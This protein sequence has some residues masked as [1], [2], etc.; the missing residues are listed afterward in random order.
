MISPEMLSHVLIPHNWKEFG[1]H[2]GCSFNLTS[3][4]NAG[5]IAGGR[6][7]R[8][9]RHTVFFTPI[10]PMGYSDAGCSLWNTT[11]AEK[12]LRLRAMDVLRERKTVKVSRWGRPL[13][14]QTVGVQDMFSRR[15]EGRC[16]P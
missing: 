5:L 14:L 1:F 2:R 9:T 10:G 8:E 16:G 11:S 12:K 15:R 3:T 7:G 13:A 4:L 6:E